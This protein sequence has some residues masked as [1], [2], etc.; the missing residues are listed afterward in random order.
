MLLIILGMLPG[1]G[2]GSL[3]SYMEAVRWNAVCEQLA[4]ESADETLIFTI[5]DIRRTDYG[6]RMVCRE[7]IWVTAD[8]RR[9]AG[10]G[11]W[12]VEDASVFCVGMRV[13]VTGNREQI[14]EA[15]N[16][17]QFDSR[18]Y[19]RSL[20]ICWKLE[21]GEVKNCLLPRQQG[22]LSGIRNRYRSSL[23]RLRVIL[24]S[25]LKKMCGENEYSLFA[26]F[27]L[28][29]KELME[30]GV[31]D[32][33]SANGLIHILTVSGMHLGL[34][35]LGLFRILRKGRCP[36]IAAAILALLV[37]VSYMVM[38]G[39]GI[40]AKRACLML[41]FQLLAECRGKNYSGINAL[42]AAV[43]VLLF[44]YP[45]QLM[46]TGF[47]Y[48]VCSVFAVCL[49][50]RMNRYEKLGTGF[51]EERKETLLKIKCRIRPGV[52]ITCLTQPIT[53]L[54]YY[55]LPVHSILL[56]LFLLPLTAPVW[57]LTFLAVAVGGRIGKLLLLPGTFFFR[58]LLAICAFF[59]GLDTPELFSFA[60]KKSI[61]YITTGSPYLWELV[62]YS[63]VVGLGLLGRMAYLR[64][65]WRPNYL[66]VA[67]HPG[68]SVGIEKRRQGRVSGHHSS[69]K[70]TEL[71]L[72][73]LLPV[74]LAFLLCRYP[75]GRLHAAFLD[76]GQGDCSVL[77]LPD[78]R[79]GMIDC[80][81]SSVLDVGSRRVAPYLD[82]IG[83]GGKIDF[84]W[85]SHADS[86]H[87]SGI[88]DLLE[89]G[90]VI[91]TLI[92]SSD[93]SYYGLESYMGQINRILYMKSGDS[94]RLGRVNCDCL[95]PDSCRIADGNTGENDDSMVLLLSTDR[96]GILYMGDATSDGVEQVLTERWLQA[97]KDSEK[98]AQTESITVLKV[99]HHGSAYSSSD[100]FL[101][102]LPN[103][104][105]AVISCGKNNYGHPASETLHRL[106]AV[107]G[108]TI[109]VT[110]WE[111]AEIL[112]VR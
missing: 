11:I 83:C 72:M 37:M 70:W 42:A 86:D 84:L 30:D 106:E 102:C 105:L 8:E 91:D 43:C 15:S 58:M 64:K 92:L 3:A 45:G 103:L 18:A 21:E 89:E 53:A 10:D 78:G 6:Y 54:T 48:S 17:G 75:D 109:H 100:A 101:S 49:A 52:I 77:R 34:A 110:W 22:G 23:Y 51:R 14:D 94:M 96:Q 2:L 32:T 63:M 13:R 56:N 68:K 62:V 79:V 93:I 5:S 60:A 61:C 88:G 24:D 1:I 7:A 95:W 90:Y 98:R 9:A 73:L 33:L 104:K 71:P 59:E 99:A 28:G 87:T 67:G 111:G 57:W 66:T 74:L 35:G 36:Y 55:R 44:F 20:G 76:V 26:A 12:Y 4:E 50:G 81:S 40:S 97:S 46:Q 41:T 69:L 27:L 38:T 31:R 29:E 19:Y 47:L 16:P 85:L 112:S 82:Y 107:E 108:I 80:G 39:E 65:R 25:R